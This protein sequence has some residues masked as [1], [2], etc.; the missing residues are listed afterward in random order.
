M[1]DLETLLKKSEEIFKGASKDQMEAIM[2]GDFTLKDMYAQ[3]QSMKKLGPFKKIFEMLPMG[4][5]GIEIPEE[6]MKLSEEKMNKF[7]YAMDSMTQEELANPDLINSS[8]IQRISKGAGVKAEEIKE[9]LNQYNMTKKMI[10]KLG[11][12]KRGLDKMLKGGLKGLPK[13]KF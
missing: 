10:K 8:R 6:H 11:K 1:G 4:G 12:N 5:M 3:V 7:I 9:M 13:F 2:K